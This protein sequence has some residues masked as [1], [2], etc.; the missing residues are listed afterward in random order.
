MRRALQLC[1]AL[2]VSEALA[3]AP[4]EHRAIWAHF[5]DIRSPE[6]VRNTVARVAAA[7]LNSIY[8]LVWY[9][10]GQAAYRSALCPMQAGT[11]DGFDPLGALIAAARPRGIA[12]HAWFVNGSYGWAR[13]GHLFTRHP[14]W[15][16]KTGVETAELWYDLG[17]PEVRAFQRDVMLECLRNY[18]LDGIH[19]DYIRF[20]GR[21]MC[22]C[23]R[24][25]AEVRDRFG[26][27]PLSAENPLFPI[28]CQMSGNPLDKPATAR[29]LAAFGDGTPAITLNTLGQGETA[30]LN[31]QAHRTPR[32]A[33]S[34]FA[35]QLLQRFGAAG[36]TVYQIRNAPTT[37]RY[38]LA[39]QEEGA[40]W[41]RRLG[42]SVA[43]VEDARLEQVPAGATV[44]FDG[45]YLITAATAAWLERFVAAGGHAIFVDGPVFA[46]HEPALQRVLGLTGTARYFSELRLAAPA[47]G[48]DLLPPGPPIDMELEG[49][50]SEAWDQFRR[51]AVTDLVRQVCTGAKALRPGAW[52]S[53]AVFNDKRSADSVCQ[54]WYGWLREGIIDYVLPMAYTESNEE[55]TRALDEW[56]AFDP[57]LARIIPGLS[58]YSR[59]AAGA[60]PRDIDLVLSQTALCRSR[61]AHGNCYFCLQH[62]TE[63][64]QQ[65][66]V[67]GPFAEPAEPYYPP[68]PAP[69][70]P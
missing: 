62:L 18:E 31:W 41:W 65:A 22:C 39:S 45:Q 13:P 50:R 10:G 30:L 48:Q 12:V 19:F 49:R 32:L 16:L 70:A 37:A 7:H 8:I 1:L 55:L 53:A 36:G 38:G 61:N 52:V 54:D 63:P 66:L 68:R 57:G 40:A 17:R 60:V 67:S 69:A 5:P 34:A 58:I 25:Q 15:Q 43:P 21:G 23:E 27:P 24:C 28:A 4:A 35:G 44:L 9:N 29:V 33:V 14:D 42:C 11:P 56:K 64:L 3:A 6:A 26:I 47:P 2:A 46:I 20:P 51:D 59:S